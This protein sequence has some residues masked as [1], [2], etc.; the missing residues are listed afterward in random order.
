MRLEGRAPSVKRRVVQR[1]A[2]ERRHDLVEARH[3]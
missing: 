2:A 1:T 3:R